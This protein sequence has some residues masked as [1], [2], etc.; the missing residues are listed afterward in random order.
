MMEVTGF[1]VDN[2][3]WMKFVTKNIYEI[4]RQTFVAQIYIGIEKGGENST[5][6]LLIFV[7]LFIYFNFKI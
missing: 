3:L 1:T 5:I 4:W 6:Y 2:V 7:I